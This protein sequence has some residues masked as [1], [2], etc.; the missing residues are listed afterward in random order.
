VQNPAVYCSHINF[1]K[2]HNRANLYPPQYSA[3]AFPQ[4]EQ[5]SWTC[6]EHDLETDQQATYYTVDR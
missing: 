5:T 2:G 6:G 3:A 1:L 4:E